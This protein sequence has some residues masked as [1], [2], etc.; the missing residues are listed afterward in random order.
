[1]Y[2]VYCK[3]NL[4]RLIYYIV[5]IVYNLHKILTKSLLYKV[6]FIFLVLFLVHVL[7]HPQLKHQNSFI[8]T[9]MINNFTH[10]CKLIKFLDINP[11]KLLNPGN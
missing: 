9:T 3:Y 11:D 8:L 4:Y 7:I 5:N 2:Y 1:M 6:C 10:T